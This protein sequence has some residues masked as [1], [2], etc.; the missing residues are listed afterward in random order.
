[1]RYCHIYRMMRP[2]YDHCQR[3]SLSGMS[4]VMLATEHLT[5]I[6]TFG[7]GFFIGVW[8]GYALKKVL[9]LAALV[10]GLFLAGIAYLQYQQILNIQ[11]N[12]L[13]CQL[14]SRNTPSDIRDM[15]QERD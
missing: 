4:K 2:Y 1:M 7:G 8:A 15:N 13:Q 5:S 3:Y 14:A 9:K 11:W 12:K 10:V 6:T